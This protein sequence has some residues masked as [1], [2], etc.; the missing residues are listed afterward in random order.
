MPWCL[1]GRNRLDLIFWF[2]SIKGKEQNKTIKNS[3]PLLY[4]KKF[5]KYFILSSLL[6]SF[7]ASTVSCRARDCKGRKKTVKTA[8]GGWM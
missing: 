8:M 5:C 2:F 1:C 6:L 3:V 7:A 4:M